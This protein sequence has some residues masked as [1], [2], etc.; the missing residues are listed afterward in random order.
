MQNK[1]IFCIIILGCTVMYCCVLIF[2]VVV[3]VV[4]CRTARVQNAS[5]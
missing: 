3:V 4:V 2:A 1:S 5:T